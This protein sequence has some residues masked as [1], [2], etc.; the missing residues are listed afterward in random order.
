MYWAAEH[1][2]PLINFLTGGKIPPLCQN[3]LNDLKNN[4]GK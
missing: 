3:C 1:S 2:G 4:G